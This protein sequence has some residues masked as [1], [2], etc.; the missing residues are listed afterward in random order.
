MEELLR[1]ILLKYMDHVG[2]CEG[3]DFI[4]DHHR[5]FYD[6]YSDAPWTDEEWELLKKI[7]N[8]ES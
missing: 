5:A 2:V 8:G 4:A 6:K 1:K 7:G 3:V